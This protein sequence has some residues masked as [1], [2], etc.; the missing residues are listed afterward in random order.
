MKPM[1]GVIFKFKRKAKATE[2]IITEEELITCRDC[3]YWKHDTCFL[4]RKA[5]VNTTANE[6]CSRAK[7]R[8]ETCKDTK[9]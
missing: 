9:S 7:K 6:Y 3:K 2:V 8:G 1:Q 4:K 5:L